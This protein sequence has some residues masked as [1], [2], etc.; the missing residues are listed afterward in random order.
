MLSRDEDDLNLRCWDQKRRFGFELLYPVSRYQDGLMRQLVFRRSTGQAVGNPL[1]AGGAG[2]RH[3]SQV[4]LTGIVGVP[5]Q[6]LADNTSLAGAG[7]TNLT[8]AQLTQQG[9]W[10]I[11][12]GDP[13]AS[14]PV[15]PADP[16]M[17]E[18]P[19]DR[20]MLSS[21]SKHPLVT[22]SLTPSDSTNPQ[23]NVINGHENVNVGS[24]SLQQACIFPLA[25]PKLCDQAAQDAD[26]S[27]RCYADDAPYNNAI[28]QPP[29]GGA[30]GTTQY[31]ASAYP[32][33]RHLQLLKAL[34]NNAVT[35][36][37]CPKIT[38][39]DAADYGYQPIMKVLATRLESA[40]N[41]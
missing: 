8:A 27:C 6:D 31:Y 39:P 33:I 10:D 41:P 37:I 16:F 34:G 18:T 21:V 9:R 5:W 26:S 1:F 28:C 35:G 22:A 14:P 36:S 24:R 40:F 32:G 17:I 19:T 30:A 38:A 29:G 3:P 7:L 2:R 25:T 11:M 4:I 23:A 12:L 13:A 20:A 15:R